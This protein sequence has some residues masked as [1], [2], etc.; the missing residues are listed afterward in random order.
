MALTKTNLA[1][2]V[3]GILPVANGGTG[4]TTTAGAANAILPSQTSN[5]GK[6]L[7]TDGTNTSWGTVTIPV[8]FPSGTVM[9]FV[10]TAA[11]T[12][13]TKSTANDNKALRVVS[14][15]AS[16]GGSVAFT[17]AFASQTPAGSVSV[18]V[19]A[20]TLAVSVGTLAVGATTLT[21]AQI[22]SHTHDPAVTNIN[23]PTAGQYLGNG[24]G[25]FS[26]GG[27]ASFGTGGTSFATAAAGGGGSHTHSISG[28]P[29]LSGAPS[30]TS[31]S[32]SGSA[33]N[34]AVQYVDVIIA[35]KD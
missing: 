4:A 28:S 23:Y 2:I 14:G 30:V 33:I 32:F 19:S 15:T 12:G 3:E 11:P 7:T 8:A 34:L 16:T 26:G 29:S 35:T 5:T 31:A 22:P 9:L 17:T 25:A 21:T 20:G 10:Q 1:N 6:Y 24:S 27:G 13:W 18:S